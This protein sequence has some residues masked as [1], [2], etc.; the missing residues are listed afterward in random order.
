VCCLEWL[1]PGPLLIPASPLPNPT[2]YRKHIDLWLAFNPGLFRY[3]E[4]MFHTHHA[5][6]VE[7]L[8]MTLLLVTS[9][10]PDS[11]DYVVAIAANILRSSPG[12]SETLGGDGVTEDLLGW[13]GT[14]ALWF[15]CGDHRR[16]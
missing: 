9:L 1:A 15:C 3:Y 16:R 4:A 7:D 14:D 13:R 10:L 11:R 8:D 2:E 6:A 12:S 5:Y